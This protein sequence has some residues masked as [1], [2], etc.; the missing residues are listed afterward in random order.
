MKKLFLEADPNQVEIK[1]LLGKDFLELSMKTVSSANP[2]RNGSWFTKE[3]QEKALASYDDKPILAYFENGDFVSHNGEWKN[4]PGTGMDFWDTL[5][6][7]GERPIGTIRG[8]DR[9]EVVYDEATGLYWTEITCALWTQYS[10]RQ[11][12]RLIEDA[13]KAAENGGP[14]KNISVE[15]DITDYEE[16]PNGVLKINDY[17]LQG[18]TILGSRNG[19]KVEPGIAG[20]QL[21]VLDVISSELY[22]RQSHALMQAYEALD[23]ALQN[24]EENTMNMDKDGNPIVSTTAPTEPEATKTEPKDPNTATFEGGEQKPE[25]K[26]EVTKTEEGVKTEN[27]DGMDPEDDQKPTKTDVVRNLAWLIDSSS[28]RLADYDSVIKHYEEADNVPGKKL[29]INTLKRMRASAEAEISDLGKILALVTADDFVE[30]E[31]REQF[32]EELCKNCRLSEV[33]AK[34]LEVEKECKTYKEKCEKFEEPCPECGENPC[35]CEK[36]K[37]EALQAEFDKV[38]EEKEKLEFSAF[39]EKATSAIE[40]AKGH[41]G[42]EFAA[43]LKERCEKKE[44]DSFEVLES[45]IALAVGKATLANDKAKNAYSAPLPTFANPD[46]GKAAEVKSKNPFERSGYKAKK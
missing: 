5:G 9:K 23:A 30:D 21:T 33:Y 34:L 24:K 27:F 35:V 40:G 20:A 1:K 13:Q 22:A 16:L 19:K 29:I 43:T 31:E 4:D 7:K 38:K 25:E 28:Y 32:E 15:V 46:Q 6:N 3:A 36:K 8:K 37:L 45:E 39:M 2:N 18:I 12:K 42:D 44:I 41:L 14:T 10:Y 11:V 26:T 17:V